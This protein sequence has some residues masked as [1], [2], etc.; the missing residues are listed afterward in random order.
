MGEFPFGN[1]HYKFSK[2]LNLR[3]EH[4]FHHQGGVVVL[5]K[6]G[7]ST[8]HYDDDEG[9]LIWYAFGKPL[10]TD[11]GC[12]YNPNFHAHPWLHNRISV[13]HAATG[14]PRAGQLRA[15]SFGEGFDFACG[16]VRIRSLYRE[17]EWPVRHRDF[18]S[19]M[20]ESSRLNFSRTQARQPDV[21]PWFGVHNEEVLADLLGYDAETIARLQ[22]DGVLR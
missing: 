14:H 20:V 8:G 15:H 10:L 3:L 13:D 16:V 19:A 12:Q 1:S 22:N 17:T 11:F 2:L 18:D 9:S 7:E 6:M 21:A 4:R 5:F